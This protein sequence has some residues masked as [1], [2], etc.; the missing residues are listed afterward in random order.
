MKILKGALILILVGVLWSTSSLVKTHRLNQLVASGKIPYGPI[1][2]AVDNYY[3]YNGLNSAFNS[4]LELKRADEFSKVEFEKIILDSL[5]PVAKQNFQKYLLPTLDLSV[6][7]QIDPFW[8]I[9]V[10]MVESGFNFK[11]QSHKNAHGLMQIRPDT[12]S[13]LYQLMNK[14]VSADGLYTNLQHPSENIEVGIF[15]LKKLL[16]NFR[17]NYRLATIAYNV[18]PNKL[19]NLLD[20]DEIDTVNFSYLAKIQDSYKDLTKN[21]VQELKKR[22]RPFEMTYVVSGQGRILE[23]RLLKLYT[24]AL[25]SCEGAFLLSSENLVHISSH[26]LPF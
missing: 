25:P 14:K 6:D 23:E 3:S 11:A 15:Y 4:N 7:Y 8:I 13:H 24:L 22:P 2:N 5:D 21:F 17:M 12:A 1:P 18:G 10:M 16:Q 19:K 20:A 26:S 9:S